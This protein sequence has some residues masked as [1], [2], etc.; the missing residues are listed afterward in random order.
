MK[1]TLP[2]FVLE[3]IADFM[4]QGWNK[5]QSTSLAWM[6][7]FEQRDAQQDA[8]LGVRGYG[9][10]NGTRID[11]YCH[12]CKDGGQLLPGTADMWIRGHKDHKTKTVRIRG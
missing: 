1:K 3:G 9:M 5:A 2:Q 11:C 8:W 6:A 12:D 7:F 4:S 10:G